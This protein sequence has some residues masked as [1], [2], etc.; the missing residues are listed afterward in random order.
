MEKMMYPLK[1]QRSAIAPDTIVAQVAAKV[2]CTMILD[3]KIAYKN[4]YL[5]KKNANSSVG[6]SSIPKWVSPM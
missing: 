1:L 6:K 3:E 2:H 4:Y 5:E